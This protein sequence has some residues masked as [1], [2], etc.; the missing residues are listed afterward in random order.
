MFHFNDYELPLLW[1]E[2]SRDHLAATVDL[3]LDED[4]A[5]DDVTTRSLCAPSEVGRARVVTRAP[6]VCAGLGIVDEFVARDQRLS[7]TR[8]KRVVD[9]SMVATGTNLVE[10]EGPLTSIL[11]IERSLLNL[12]GIAMGTATLTAEYVAAVVGTKAVVCDTRKTVP[13][14]RWL[15]KYAV[16]C[17]GGHSHRWGL[18]DALLVKDNHIAGLAV[19][20]YTQR[21]QTAVE[22]LRLLGTPL[23]FVCA[24]ADTLQQ[25][26]ALLAL[27][28][29][30][31][32]IALLDNFSNDAL[33]T[34][35]ARRDRSRPTLQIEASGGV[36]LDS[37]SAIARTGVDRISVGALT[38]SAR[39]ADVA[40]D[41]NAG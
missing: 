5:A 12:L 29:G 25:F 2:L 23:S 27:P 35:V 15:Q 32:D 8:V 26:D 7:A 3:A 31:I 10:L 1:R 22:K 33:V 20:E 37:I 38:H 11:P 6:A 41:I 17:G 34:A 30:I 13:G 14:L 19:D 9:G 4:G 21:I 16:R 28:V 18:G 40:L 36:N 39:W 24:E